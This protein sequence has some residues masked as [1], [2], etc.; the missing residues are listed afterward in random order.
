MQ[1]FRY[2]IHSFFRFVNPTLKNVILTYNTQTPHTP[3]N[4]QQNISKVTKFPQNSN[5]S[6]KEI[7][8]ALWITTKNKNPYEQNIYT[9]EVKII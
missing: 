9:F 6:W 1:V 2:L 4:H 7:H 8:Y 5:N 3:K